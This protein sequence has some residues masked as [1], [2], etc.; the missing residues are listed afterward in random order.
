MNIFSRAIKYLY[1]LRLK[2]RIAKYILNRES[3][4]IYCRIGK[5]GSTLLTQALE[6]YEKKNKFQICQFHLQKAL[7]KKKSKYIIILR[8]PIRR[9]I[10]AFYSDEHKS[11]KML[12]KYG[13]FNLICENLFIK[14]NRIFSRNINLHNELNTFEHI[15][16]NIQ[17]HL[18]KVINKLKS[19]QIFYI[20]TQENLSK[21]I[22]EV[23]KIKKNNTV[24]LGKY[25]KKDIVLS[26]LAKENLKKFLKIEYQYIKKLNKLKK[27]DKKS[28]E[29][30]IN[31]P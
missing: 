1:P 20:F 4:I 9:T 6:K 30:L 12:K 27:I 22:F 7:F 23:L 13:S 5:S 18:E 16:K 8:N 25:N 2:S 24:N 21:E 26:N 10:S 3:I 19:D 11:K 31:Y 14:K 17:F 29:K 28:Y 15:K